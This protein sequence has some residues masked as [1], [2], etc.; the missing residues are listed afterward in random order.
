LQELD[1]SVYCMDLLVMSG[2]VGIDTAP[3]A[4][5]ETHEL[6]KIFV[7]IVRPAKERE[8]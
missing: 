8:R 6:I 1:E 2:I 5:D 7:T 3:N 4:A